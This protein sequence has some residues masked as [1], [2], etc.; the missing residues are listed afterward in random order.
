MDRPPDDDLWF[1]YFFMRRFA[2]LLTSYH[3]CPKNQE[4]IFRQKDENPKLGKYVLTGKT[5]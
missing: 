4:G 3:T 1:V 2:F 5:I